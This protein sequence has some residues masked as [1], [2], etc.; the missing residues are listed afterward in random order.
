MT[1]GRRTQVRYHASSGIQTLAKARHFRSRSLHASHAYP[2]LI[3]SL[4]SWPKDLDE[5][6]VPLNESKRVN[7]PQTD[8]SHWD[9]QEYSPVLALS[10]KTV[11]AFCMYNACPQGRPRR[12]LQTASRL[13]HCRSVSR[14]RRLLPRACSPRRALRT[15]TMTRHSVTCRPCRIW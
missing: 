1:S 2:N 13:C 5:Y 9:L 12:L 8:R 3:V 7:P 15:M 11:P 10:S 4:L 6:A 14:R